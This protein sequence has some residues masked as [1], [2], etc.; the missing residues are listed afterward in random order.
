MTK[1]EYTMEV[2]TTSW[3]GRDLPPVLPDWQPAPYSMSKKII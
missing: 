1:E 3:T 2:S